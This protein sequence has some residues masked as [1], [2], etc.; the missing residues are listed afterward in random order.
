MVYS[1][2]ASSIYNDIVTGLVGITS[3]PKIS[4]DQI[5]DEIV[6]ER[7]TV[8]KEYSLKIKVLLNQILIS[9]ECITSVRLM[10]MIIL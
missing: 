7:L 3:N 9:L 5:E 1:K 2:L 10:N 8:I 4:I 6:E